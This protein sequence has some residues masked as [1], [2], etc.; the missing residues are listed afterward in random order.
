MEDDFLCILQWQGNFTISSPAGSGNIILLTA[1]KEICYFFVKW[2]NSFSS[3]IDYNNYNKSEEQLECNRC[4]VLPSLISWLF[5]LI[6]LFLYFVQ[7]VVCQVSMAFPLHNFV[8]LANQYAGTFELYATAK[9]ILLE[10]PFPSPD[11]NVHLRAGSR[12]LKMHEGW[13]LSPSSVEQA[14]HFGFH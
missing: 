11:W 3:I 13:Q 7:R 2:V 9:S 4:L 6:L 8:S 14:I 12:G 5:R 1:N 10:M